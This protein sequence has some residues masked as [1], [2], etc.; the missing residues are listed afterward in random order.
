MSHIPATKKALKR[1]NALTKQKKGHKVEVSLKKNEEAII[2]RRELNTLFKITVLGAYTLFT[3]VLGA[4]FAT[5]D[6]SSITDQYDKIFNLLSKQ[7]KEIVI[8]QKA[9]SKLFL[10]E[11]NKELAMLIRNE[12]NELIDTKEGRLD[13]MFHKQE[14]ENDKLK[15]KL[16]TLISYR[17]PA[18][19]E[20]RV[21][22]NT[23][24][25]NRKNSDVLYYK[26]DLLIKQES[27]KQK[28][29]E[30][31]FLLIHPLDEVKNVVKWNDFQDRQKLDIYKLKKEFEKERRDFRRNK[32]RIVSN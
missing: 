25:Y 2:I 4:R 6:N 5:T 16:N 7:K 23:I 21:G 31:A 3:F 26:H 32:Y 22:K 12:L 18:S 30:E 20:G 27:R 29:E 24:P 15:R 1:N 19:L 13:V 8:P 28:K 14:I 17:S 10:R 11:N 9:E